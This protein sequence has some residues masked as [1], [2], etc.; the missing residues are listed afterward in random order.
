MD[1]M[2]QRLA[3]EIRKHAHVYDSSS[4][5]YKDSQ[6]IANSWEEISTTIGLDVIECT[7]RWRTMR[8]KYVRL[9]KRLSTQS[10]DPLGHKV[11][12]FYVRLSW[13]A[14]HVKHR[15][16]G[17]TNYGTNVNITCSFYHKYLCC[18][19]LGLQASGQHGVLIWAKIILLRNKNVICKLIGSNCI[20]LT[21]NVNTIT[22]SLFCR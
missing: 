3:E 17:S 20:W 15:E 16:R 12:S 8:D 10:G 13:L 19:R 21:H 4:P 11:P 6:M 5:H 18:Q 9:R 1:L 22:C 2:E 14:P 7:K